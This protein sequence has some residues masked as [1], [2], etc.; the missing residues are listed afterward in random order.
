VRVKRFQTF[1][2]YSVD[3]AGAGMTDYVAKITRFAAEGVIGEMDGVYSAWATI[4][5]GTLAIFT[6]EVSISVPVMR[7]GCR[8]PRNCL[9]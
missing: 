6:A 9:R 4:G 8:I 7:A 5:D 3:V 1:H 2:Y